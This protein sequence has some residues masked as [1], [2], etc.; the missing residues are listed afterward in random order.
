MR[1]GVDPVP[2]EAPARQAE[3]P[4]ATSALFERGGTLIDGESPRA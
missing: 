4:G 2:M 3:I 1:G